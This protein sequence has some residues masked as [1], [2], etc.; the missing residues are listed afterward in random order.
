MKPARKSVLI[1]MLRVSFVLLIITLSFAL[2]T[3][4]T[5]LPLVSSS[6]S[7]LPRFVPGRTS[8]RLQP[9]HLVELRPRHPHPQ[10]E[11]ADEPRAE[12]QRARAPTR[13][14]TRAAHEAEAHPGRQPARQDVDDLSQDGRR[15]RD[16]ESDR[17]EAD[18]YHRGHQAVPEE[19][20]PGPEPRVERE[21]DVGA[22]EQAHDEERERHHPCQD[23]GSN[24][25]P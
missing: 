21:G 22:E 4:Q 15:S 9:E 5:D 20:E 17:D 7:P 23:G 1:S 8:L 12:G 10:A 19:P 14:P 11:E 2:T 16:Q 24:G 13:R 25:V 6:T 18:D 3:D